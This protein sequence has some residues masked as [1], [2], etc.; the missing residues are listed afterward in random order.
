[1]C[2]RSTPGDKNSTASSNQRT[3]AP[4]NPTS[5]FASPLSSQMSSSLSPFLN[6]MAAKSPC[7]FPRLLTRSPSSTTAATTSSLLA[8]RRAIAT[9]STA[10]S[11][12]MPSSTRATSRF[13]FFFFFQD[14][15]LTS[16]SWNQTKKKGF[17][18]EAIT[19]RLSDQRW[20]VVYRDIK[21]NL[22]YLAWIS[23][24]QVASI[25][26]AVACDWSTVIGIQFLADDRILVCTDEMV[27]IIHIDEVSFSPFLSFPPFTSEE[28]KKK[29]Q[30][31]FWAK[32]RRRANQSCCQQRRSSS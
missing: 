23:F 30:T 24:A 16:F 19:T 8:P 6:S 5:N 1:M 20:I 31:R 3:C 14:F 25:D 28:K 27:Q 22:R 29:K 15:H 11:L 17:A 26:C 10:V 9:F 7:L 18:I 2:P 32:S 4:Q 21:T 13:F 12:P